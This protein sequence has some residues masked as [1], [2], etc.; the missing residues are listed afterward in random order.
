MD[1]KRVTSNSYSFTSLSIYRAF[2]SSQLKRVF[3]A[4]K[5]PRPVPLESVATVKFR[6]NPGNFRVGIPFRLLQSFAEAQLTWRRSHRRRVVPVIPQ[7]ATLGVRVFRATQKERPKKCGGV[8]R[9]RDGRRCQDRKALSGSA[10]L[11]GLHASPCMQCR[12]CSMA[13]PSSVSTSAALCTSPAFLPLF[14]GVADT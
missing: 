4:G 2:S 10:D 11:R 12:A 1:G 5:P 6:R 8:A 3:C 9:L 7:T 14:V 13:A